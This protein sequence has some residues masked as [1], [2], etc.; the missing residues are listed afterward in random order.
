M[1]PQKKKFGIKLSENSPFIIG[2]S[3]VGKSSIVAKYATDTFVEGKE[4]TIGGRDF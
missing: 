4:A 1:W 2:E 3:S